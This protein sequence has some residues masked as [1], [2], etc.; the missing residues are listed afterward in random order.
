MKVVNILFQ[1]ILFALLIGCT[2]EKLIPVHEEP[3]IDIINKDEPILP[4]IETP[5]SILSISIQKEFDSAKTGWSVQGAAC[6]GDYLFQFSDANTPVI[7][8]SM[9]DKILIA[10]VDLTKEEKNHCNNAS[11]SNIFYKPN[12]EFP[13]LYV[14]GGSVGTYN[15]I[16]VYRI[17]RNDTSFSF[18]MIQEIILPEASSINNL[19]WTDAIMD[20]DNSVMYVT[21]NSQNGHGVISVFKIP[22]TSSSRIKLKDSDIIQQILIPSFTHHQ[23]A[24]I[25][26]NKLYIFDG[27]PGWGDTNYLRIVDLIAKRDEFLINL[28]RKKFNLEVEGAFFWKNELYC[29]TN[30][31]GV[32]KIIK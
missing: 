23:G 13:L 21:S 4:L 28:T 22:K 30:G 3:G 31:R 20:N 15:R 26:N 11:F 1:A 8:Y 6:Y 18:S 10:T 27:V 16:Q 29:I 25:K 12:D 32:Y 17:T 14:S 7:I 19:Y 2:K 5:D 24:C 9:K